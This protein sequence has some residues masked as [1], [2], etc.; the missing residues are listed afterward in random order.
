MGAALTRRKLQ[1]PSA[2]AMSDAAR[3]PD[4]LCFERVHITLLRAPW[5]AVG[6]TPHALSDHRGGVGWCLFL[7]V[8]RTHGRS[9][10]SRSASARAISF[11]RRRRQSLVVATGFGR[12]RA[13][14]SSRRRLDA[15][16]DAAARDC[17]PSSR[18]FDL[19]GRTSPHP[20]TQRCWTVKRTRETLARRWSQVAS[21]V[22]VRALSMIASR[23]RRRTL[24]VVAGV[25][26]VPSRASSRRSGDPSARS[27]RPNVTAWAPRADIAPPPPPSPPSLAAPASRSRRTARD[28]RTSRESTRAPPPPRPPPPPR[29]TRRATTT[30]TTTTAM[31]RTRPTRV[32]RAVPSRT[33]TPPSPRARPRATPLP[34]TRLPPPRRPS[35]RLP[36]PLP[37]TSHLPP[38]PRLP[39]RPL[40]PSARR[41][42]PRLPRRRVPPPDPRAATSIATSS[43]RHARP[44][45]A[46]PHPRRRRRRRRRRRSPRP[47][48]STRWP[49]LTSTRWRGRNVGF[50]SKPRRASV[51]GPCRTPPAGV[52]RTPPVRSW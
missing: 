22:S 9:R 44:P 25:G 48:R 18:T 32:R 13:R 23:R 49:R 26:C 6:R 41:T 16:R 1:P 4:A 11:A 20:Q 31:R 35:P 5:S 29:R 7:I 46:S 8:G 19:V 34:P 45:R 37:V 47:R 27:C 10:G 12:V 17:L 15:R 39:R 28:A 21:R 30:T 3:G 40:R 50:T 24:V 51:C 2:R 43:R 33:R 52:P 14:D 36:P 42:R 38:P